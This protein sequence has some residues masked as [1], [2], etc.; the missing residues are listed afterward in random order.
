MIWPGVQSGCRSFSSAAAPATCGLD[1]DVP[2]IAWN[3]SPWGPVSGSAESGVWPARIWTPGAVT[4]GLLTPSAEPGP[5]R[6]LKDAMTSPR[7]R[8]GSPAV[9]V[10]LTLALAAR[11]ASSAVPSANW[12]WLVGQEVVV[13][14]QVR[15]GG[16]L[17]VEDH[18]RRSALQR[19]SSPC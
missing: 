19:R 12:M 14:L 11:K 4:S 3:S 13:G 5:P 6:E 15:D 2:A 8:T 16:G 10:A 17:V 7:S 1:I 18:A 9:S